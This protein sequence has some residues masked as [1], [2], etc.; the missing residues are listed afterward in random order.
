MPCSHKAPGP[1]QGAGRPNAALR[2]RAARRGSA[3]RTKTLER[4]REIIGHRPNPRSGC[5]QISLYLAEGIHLATIGC[6]FS[7]QTSSVRPQGVLPKEVLIRVSNDGRTVF[8]FF[9]HIYNQNLGDA[10]CTRFSLQPEGRAG[11]LT[12]WAGT[13]WRLGSGY[14]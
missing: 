6:Y 8:F 12:S 9:S 10:R 2:T 3:A 5:P 7:L 1:R 4:G 14:L 13:R 11:C